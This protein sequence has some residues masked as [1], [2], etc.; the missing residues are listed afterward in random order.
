MRADDSDQCIAHLEEAY[1]DIENMEDQLTA[2]TKQRD[3]WKTIR[4]EEYDRA[5]E[6][7]E[8]LK[9]S[10]FT[11]TTLAE[12]YKEQRDRL[13]EALNRISEYQGVDDED[14]KTMA[15]KALQ[16]LTQNARAMTPA[17]ESD[18]GK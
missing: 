12:N 18:H 7:I 9:L 17:T 16:S 8:R 15:I 2:V 6:R 10:A 3:M 13:A 5:I 4:R 11:A 1:L 14:P